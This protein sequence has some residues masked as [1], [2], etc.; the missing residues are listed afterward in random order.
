MEQYMH[1][2]IG[3]SL[4][5]VPTIRQRYFL[6][7]GTT[8]KGLMTN[9]PID[10]EHFL[11]YVHDIPVADYLHQDDRLRAV[12]RA[13]P[14]PKWILTNSDTAHATRVLSALG[15]LDLF[16]GILDITKMDFENKPNPGVFH[17]ALA[18]AGGARAE[19]SVFVDDIPHNL[20]QARKLGW[21]TV[22]VG[23]KPHLGEADFQIADIY[24]LDQVLK[25]VN[26]G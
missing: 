20:D 17:K 14:K 6:E 16:E 11:A 9:H 5:Q 26:H 19:S 10:P 23:D 21:I 7:Y 1:K 25:Q 24:Q 12:L 3:I 2:V 15:L 22:L 18:F 4:D 8:L 13:I